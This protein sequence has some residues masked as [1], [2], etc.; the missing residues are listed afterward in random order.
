[1]PPRFLP[2]LAVSTLWLGA[3]GCASQPAPRAAPIPA[4]RPATDGDYPAWAKAAGLL[5]LPFAGASHTYSF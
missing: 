4:E 3:A 2:I 5:L 1:M